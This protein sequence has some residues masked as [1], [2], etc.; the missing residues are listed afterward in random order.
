MLVVSDSVTTYF[1]D[2]LREVDAPESA[3]VRL[4]LQRDGVEIAVDEVRPG[5]TCFESGD[6][7]VLVLDSQVATLLENKSL[8]IRESD[9]G[10]Q[11]ALS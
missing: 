7:T 2:W 6:R 3:C 4:I 9:D 11:L 5:D 1:S 8:D 10:P